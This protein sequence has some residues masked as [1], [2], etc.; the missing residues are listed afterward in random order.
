ME[1]SH[2]DMCQELESSRKDGSGSVKEGRR[3]FRIRKGEGSLNL[4]VERRTLSTRG[5]VLAVFHGEHAN[6]M[7]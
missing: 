1:A 4:D 7:A 3:C 5:T 2:G 6:A